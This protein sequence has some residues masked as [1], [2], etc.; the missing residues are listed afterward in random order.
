V[1]KFISI[2]GFI[3][4]IASDQTSEKL[5]YSFLHIALIG[6]GTVNPLFAAWIQDNT[7]D[8]ATC[9]V[10]IGFFG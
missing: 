10:M 6:A 7:P 5:R 1:A 3:V 2:I 8:T 9:S 4:L